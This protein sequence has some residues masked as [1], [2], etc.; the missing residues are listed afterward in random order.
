MAETE[1]AVELSSWEFID[2]VPTRQEVLDLLRTLDPVWSIKTVDFADFVLPLPATKKVKRKVDGRQV[3][4]HHEVYTL[5]MTVGGRI[6]MANAA[7]EKHGWV[8]SFVP[9]PQTPSGFPGYIEVGERIVYREHV[10]IERWENGVMV[11]MGKRTGQAAVPVSGGKQAAGS[12]PWEKVETSARGR[13]L[14]AW[15]FGVLPGSGVASFEEMMATPEERRE[16][17]AER[18]AQRKSRDELIDELRMTAEAV[19]QVRETTP[20]EMAERMQAYAER[21][22]GVTLV[23]DP[24]KGPILDPLKDGQV[25]LMINDMNA[26]LQRNRPVE[27]SGG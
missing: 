18:V 4:E 22:F 23:V 6:K 2:R 17:A 15:G 9:E 7:Q 14:A 8:M 26:T 21:A 13:S 5:Y 10:V 1:E 25:Q 3:E 19:R 20:E 24:Q 12:N 16:I 11:P 27:V